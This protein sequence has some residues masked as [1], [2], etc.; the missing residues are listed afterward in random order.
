[1]AERPSQEDLLEQMK[2]LR[3]SD[4]LL[5]LSMSLVSLGFLRL[6][7]E[8]RDLDQARLATDALR[9][10]LPLLKERVPE[11]LSRDLSQALANLQLAYAK[12]AA[13]QPA[14]G[15]EG[16]AET[17]AAEAEAGPSEAAPATPEAEPA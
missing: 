16:A 5:D 9:A 10:L 13:E 2:Q 1:V 17:P 11:D 15:G 4:I 6:G 7:S 12:A 14:G 3:V 8:L